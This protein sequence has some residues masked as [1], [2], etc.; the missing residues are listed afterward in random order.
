MW[1]FELVPTKGSDVT[2][3]A[4]ADINVVPTLVED[5]FMVTGEN[6]SS[7]SIASIAGVPL[8]SFDKSDEYYVGD[9]QS[10]IYIVNIIKD[11]RIIKRFSIL[12]Q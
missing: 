11:G 3:I 7:V 8:R 9:L 1:G 12:K 6:F 4:Y 10:G 2:N 5:V